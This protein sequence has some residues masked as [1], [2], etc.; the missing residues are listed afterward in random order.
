[1]PDVDQMREVF[2]ACVYLSKRPLHARDEEELACRVSE[3]TGLD[4]NICH[5]S[6]MAL[7]DMQLVCVNEKPFRLAVPPV[8]KTDPNS[9]AVWRRIQDTK[10]QMAS[11]SKGGFE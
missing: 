7:K 9:S 6:L 2:K 1:M 4:I 5:L 11:M 10:I 8:K 3:E